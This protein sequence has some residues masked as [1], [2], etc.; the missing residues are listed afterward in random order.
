[1]QALVKTA[2]GYGNVE[3]QNIDEPEP[4]PEQV[5]VLVKA[6]GICGTDI[7]IFKN[8]YPNNPP[9]VLGHEFSGEVVE[10]GEGV[11]SCKVG[12]KISA[13]TYMVTCGH[14]IYCNTGRDNLCLERVSIGSGENGAFA[15]YIIVPEKN[16]FHLPSNI[17]YAA[18]ALSE[19]LSCCIHAVLEM[20]QV[21]VG[22]MVLI[23][24]PGPM[25]LISTQL[26]KISGGYVVVVG[27]IADK[28]R[29]ELAK[30][31]GADKIML[32]TEVR[33]LTRKKDKYI[34]DVALECSGV[35]AGVNTGISLLRKGGRFTQIGLMGNS[36]KFPI[37]EIVYKEIQ[38][39]GTFAHTWSAW[40]TAM[41]L[42]SRGLVKTKQ[43]IS[44]QLPL[45]QWKKGFE[46]MESKKGIKIL[47]NP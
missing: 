2:L 6:A 28:E 10:C 36:I 44:H 31:L 23:T 33:E 13:R 26:A 39:Y 22:E 35:E 3:I 46:L 24:G 16:I 25:G 18:G 1:M 14:C 42:L 38:F 29:L 19:P 45:N 7:H 27:T 32:D 20:T 43:L 37:D 5:K 11:Q 15:K 8:E 30:K 9:V 17:S 34:F 40:N 12:D 47:L 41:T 4:G 21:S